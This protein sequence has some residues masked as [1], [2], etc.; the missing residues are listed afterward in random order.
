MKYYSRISLAISISALALWICALSTYTS[1]RGGDGMGPNPTGILL[2]ISTWLV[3]GILAHSTIAAAVWGFLKGRMG[4][5]RK[6]QITLWINV[7]L[8]TLFL[9]LVKKWFYF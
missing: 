3:A 4:V 2:Y 8:W 5:A 6:R 7:I 1:P 9:V